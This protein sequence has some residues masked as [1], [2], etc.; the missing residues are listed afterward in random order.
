ML[1]INHPTI[2]ITLLF[3]V[4][5]ITLCEQPPSTTLVVEATQQQ[6]AHEIQMT[7]AQLDLANIQLGYPERKPI[8]QT[9]ACRGMVEVPPNHLA[10]VYAP[11]EGFVEEVPF[12]VGDFVKKGTLITTIRNPALLEK[13]S[14][15]LEAKAQLTF[16]KQDFQRKVKLDSVHATSGIQVEQ[17]EAAYQSMLNHYSG[18]KALLKALGV[19]VD[20]LEHTHMVQTHI[21]I[22]A[23]IS[24]YVTKVEINLGKSIT[25]QDLLYELVDVSHTH[26]ELQL[27]AVDLPKIKTGQSIYATIPGDSTVY[28]AKVYRL[29]RQIDP[30]TKTAL[31]HG[32]FVQEPAP[33]L[34]GTY[35]NSYIEVAT[36][37]VLAVPRSAI[38]QTG[39]STQIVVEK[40]PLTFQLLDVELG[41]SW[42]GWTAISGLGADFHDRIVINGAYYFQGGEE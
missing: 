9:V 8:P 42:R 19:Q 12:I 2:K 14:A 16:L 18:L 36:D 28:E 15:L 7:A 37:S 1:T 34:P 5:G 26:L 11:T 17:A 27:F 23:P 33:I 31:V 24:G 10:S 20:R 39:S 40:E 25:T 29:A 30:K 4:I 3:L 32:H 6:E 35:L 13:Q 22:Y 21:P 41:Q 38:L